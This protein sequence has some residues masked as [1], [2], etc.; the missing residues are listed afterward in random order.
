MGAVVKVVA[1]V[2]VTV[3][4]TMPLAGEKVGTPGQTASGP[5]VNG[6]GGVEEPSLLIATTFAGALSRL[7]GIA[8]SNWVAESITSPLPPVPPKVTFVT[9]GAVKPV[10]V[11]VTSHWSEAVAGVTAVTVGIAA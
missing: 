4:P 1:V 5:V 9:F 11:I 10:P 2:I 3:E 6:N 8:T 7:F